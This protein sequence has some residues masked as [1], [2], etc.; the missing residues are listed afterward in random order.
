MFDTLH[1]GMHITS[2][3]QTIQYFFCIVI[4]VCI[5]LSYLFCS[6]FCCFSL[7]IYYVCPWV[8]CRHVHMITCLYYFCGCPYSPC[9]VDDRRGMW[10]TTSD[11]V[12]MQKAFVCSI[13]MNQPVKHVTTPRR[14]YSTEYY[15]NSAHFCV[16]TFSSCRYFVFILLYNTSNMVFPYGHFRVNEV[17]AKLE[18]MSTS[19]IFPLLHCIIFRWMCNG[20][21]SYFCR[22]PCV[23]R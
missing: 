18:K 5:C 13:P 6:F 12:L 20:S 14:T 23:H 8:D 4:L 10:R 9:D 16:W 1:L 17:I 7:I 21:L 19:Q 3:E 11:C 2:C 15:C 22:P